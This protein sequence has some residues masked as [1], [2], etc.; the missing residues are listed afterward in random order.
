MKVIITGM[1]RSGTS[2]IAG[3]LKICGLYLGDSLIMGLKDNP[4]G[5]FEDRAFVRLNN[6]ILKYNG[7]SWDRP[8]KEIKTNKGIAFNMNRYAE[9]WPKDRPVGWKDP[10]ACL[11]LHLWRKAVSSEEL[12]VVLVSR[13]F[14]EIVESLKKRN[15]FP[16]AK[17]RE[18]AFVYMKAAVE[19][20]EET[21]LPYI[22]TIYNNYF[23]VG[24][25]SELRPMLEFL[26]LDQG[27]TAI[28]ADFIDADLWHHRSENEPGG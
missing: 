5:H 10:R 19:H 18:L 17:S 7:G 15:R 26:G 28:I 1:H 9:S 24:W 2:M 6:E 13:P 12:K 25:R 23:K 8:P 27:P 22:I 11:T 14:D 4:R 3:L 21:R 16:E 20:L